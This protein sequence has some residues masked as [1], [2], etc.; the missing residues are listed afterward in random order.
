MNDSL[1]K[2]ASFTK[3]GEFFVERLKTEFAGVSDQFLMLFNSKNNPI[4]M[5][6]FAAS[7]QRAAPTALKIADYILRK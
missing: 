3:I 7:N 6:F 4:F 2:D 1:E 5:L